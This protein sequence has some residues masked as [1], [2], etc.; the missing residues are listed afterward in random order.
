LLNTPL[1]IGSHPGSPWLSDL[2][3]TI[4]SGRDVRVH[5][6]GGYEIAAL[7][8]ACRYYDR[9][10][11]LQDSTQVLHPDFWDIID[12]SSPA[13][14]FG[15]PPMYMGVY[16]RNQLELAI[17]DAP[18]VMDKASSIAW[19]G[20]LSDRLPYTALWP[21]VTDATGRFEERHGRNNLVLEN[22][23]LRKWKGS[24]GQ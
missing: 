11:F 21:E 17:P 13:W 12:G 20:A 2:L 18:A 10:V 24:W 1:V 7:R 22:K 16:N 19:E 5:R 4:P 3:K 9:F 23:Y 15:G 6:D 8:T 14:L